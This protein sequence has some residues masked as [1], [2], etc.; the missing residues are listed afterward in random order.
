MD[1]VNVDTTNQDQNT[2]QDQSQ[3]LGW[4]AGLP[5][6]LKSHES[7]TPYKTVGEFAKAHIET[8]GKVSELEGKLGSAI[9]KPGDDATPEQREQFYRSIGK[10]EKPD[11]YEFPKAEGIEHDPKMVEWAQK[12]FHEA[13]L[14]TDQAKA[15]SQAWDGFMGQMAKADQEARERAVKEAETSLKTEWGADYDK[16]CELAKRAFKTFADTE[17][18]AFL[19][20]SKLGNAPLLSKAFAKI[21]KLMGEDTGLSGATFK[22]EPPKV[23]MNYESMQ[24]FHKGG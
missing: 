14:N 6:D 13:N 9:F 8:A 21:G 23:G 17:L 12:T 2:N 1:Q 15:V 24:D 19:D 5:D 4:R 20:E 22:G 3:S 16:N 7:F 18:I 11:A 10:P